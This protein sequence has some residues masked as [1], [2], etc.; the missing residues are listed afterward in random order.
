MPTEDEVQATLDRLNRKIDEIKR[1][2]A[3]RDREMA[4]L[5]SPF[6]AMLPKER[7]LSQVLKYLFDE[8]A[9]HGQGSSFLEQ[10]IKLI[11]S[12]C[13]EVQHAHVVTEHPVA[14][15]APAKRVRFID[16]VIRLG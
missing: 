11:G 2:W 12:P 5:F 16:L 9:G 15:D 1:T 10:F 3:N 14:V 7:S 8:N 13:S 4:P 6:E